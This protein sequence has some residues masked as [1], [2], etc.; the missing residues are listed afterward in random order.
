MVGGIKIEIFVGSLVLMDSPFLLV[1]EC[2]YRGHCYVSIL[3]LM[4]SP[5][6]RFMQEMEEA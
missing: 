2:V 3:V 4:D 5:F 1:R 6:L